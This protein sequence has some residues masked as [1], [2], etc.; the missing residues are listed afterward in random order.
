MPRLHVV[1]CPRSG[2]T[3]LMELLATCFHCQRQNGHELSIFA[4]TGVPRSS[5]QVFLSKQPTDIL[6]VGKL[7][8]LD[9]DLYVVHLLRDPRAVITS[10][11]SGKSGLDYF[12]N[13]RIWKQCELAARALEGHPH[14]LHLRYE[15]L[16]RHPNETQA[17]IAAHFPFLR[18]RYSFA[19]YQDFAHPD[20]AARAAMNG[21]RAIDTG[22]LTKWW[23]HLPRAKSQLLKFPTMQWD[24][25]H[26]GYEPNADWQKLLKD[27]LPQPHSCRYSDRPQYFKEA[28]KK[29]RLWFKI[30]RY[31]RQAL[32]TPVQPRSQS[33]EELRP[34]LSEQ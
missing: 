34:R 23:Q 28:E 31:R 24:L 11:H 33:V 12:S 19:E 32:S 6:H 18:S 8:D 16:V 21:L 20:P 17:R 26:Y 4:P 5:E 30:R 1:G 25:E 29:L 7:L 9:P 22:S 13:Y 14:V 3:L 2:T 27:V 15:S 10:R